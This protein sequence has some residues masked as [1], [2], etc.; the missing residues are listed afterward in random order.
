MTTA[1]SDG[2]TAARSSRASKKPLVLVTGAAGNLG[3]SLAAALAPDY[4][5]VGMDMNAPADAPYPIIEIDLT[6]DDSVQLAF[7]ELREQ[8]GERIASVV[9]LVAFFDF[10]GE[11]NPLYEAVNVQGTRRLLRALAD[12][13]TEQFL[14]ASTMLVHEPC[15]PGERIDE[16]Q[17]FGPRWEYPKSKLAAENVI[18]DEHGSIPYA[19]LR[20]A[21]VYDEESTVPTMAQQMTR[22]YERDFESHLY[23]G[24]TLVGQ[25][26]LHREDMI[27]AVRR[28]VAGPGELWIRRVLRRPDKIIRACGLGPSSVTGAIGS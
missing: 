2:A 3:R 9:H 26:M 27:D 22:I 17:P 28:T 24:S 19:I 6:S 1:N 12:F 10:S 4:R 16:N 14:Y 18:R 21:G 11:P 15:K 20:L 5:V 13:E 25:S 8:H 7:R 23:S